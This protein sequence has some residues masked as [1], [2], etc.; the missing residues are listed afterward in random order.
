MEW[1]VAICID[2][3]KEVHVAVAST[4][5]APSSTGSAARARWVDRSRGRRYDC[6]SWCESRERD[7]SAR[8]EQS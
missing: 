5:L 7:W 6:R 3:H 2:T 1:T 8:G 4:R